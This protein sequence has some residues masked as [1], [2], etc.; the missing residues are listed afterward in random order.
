MLSVVFVVLPGTFAFLLWGAY[1]KRRNYS[2]P[3]GS[4]R[5]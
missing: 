3:E 2:P 1:R 4:E 5:W